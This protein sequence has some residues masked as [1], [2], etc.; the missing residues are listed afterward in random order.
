LGGKEVEVG[1][2]RRRGRGE[3]GAIGKAQKKKTVLGLNLKIVPPQFLTFR[4]FDLLK[5][6]WRRGKRAKRILGVEPAFDSMASWSFSLQREKV[7]RW[8]AS[9]FSSELIVGLM[10]HQG[11]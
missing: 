6:T 10:K 5:Q 2:D 7:A 1:G 9:S 4:P 11:D 8:Y 3:E